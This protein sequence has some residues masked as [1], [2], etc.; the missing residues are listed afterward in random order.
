M[1]PTEAIGVVAGLMLVALLLLLAKYR[2]LYRQVQE[3]RTALRQLL[4]QW[5]TERKAAEDQT[6]QLVASEK[7]LRARE[8]QNRLILDT[9]QDAFVAINAD[10]AI[11]EWNPQAETTFGWSRAEALGRPLAETIIPP[12]HRE[13]HL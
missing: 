1:I 12:P 4:E 10:D 11:T 8:E 13:A 5:E 3:E 6:R 2:S 9:A 7:A